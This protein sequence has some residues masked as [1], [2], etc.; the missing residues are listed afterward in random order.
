MKKV[1]AKVLTIGVIFSLFMTACQESDTTEGAEI[2]SFDLES[3]AALETS[4][5]EV[6]LISD[7]GLQTLDESSTGRFMRDR[8]LECAEVTKDTVE[9]VITIDFGD[10]CE[11]PNG[12]VKKGKIIIEYDGRMHE[13]GSFRKVTLEDFYIDSLHVEGVRT[14]TNVTEETNA[15]NSWSFNA[16]IVG[17]KITLPD[18]SFATREAD[19][20]RTVFLFEDW[21]ESY[22]TLDGSA[23]GVLF[24]GNEYE[25]SILETLIFKR[26]CRDGRIV[27]PV[28]GIKQIIVGDRTAVIDYGEGDCDNLVRVD[29]NGNSFNRILRPRGRRF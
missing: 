29:V 1:I 18:G 15:D 11:C 9:Q 23:T 21:T 14:L 6:D 17:G 2:A 10:G 19:H 22:A 13:V 27:Q 3:E 24:N 7:A 8:I 12:V 4:F 16:T 20:A 5:E 26:G 25:I 28:D